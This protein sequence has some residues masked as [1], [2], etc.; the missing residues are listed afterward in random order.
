MLKGGRLSAKPHF[1]GRHP[2]TLPMEHHTQNLREENLGF[3][4]TSYI[5]REG[6]WTELWR[7]DRF[8]V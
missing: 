2:L 6:L 4:D 1:E 8:L 5:F 7:T 3:S